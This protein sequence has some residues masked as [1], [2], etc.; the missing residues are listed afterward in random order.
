MDL[1]QK[2]PEDEEIIYQNYKLPQQTIKRM[3][4]MYPAIRDRGTGYVLSADEFKINCE[5]L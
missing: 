3:K 2:Y 5:M 1:T 4:Q